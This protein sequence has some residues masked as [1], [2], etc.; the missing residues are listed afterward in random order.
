[1]FHIKSKNLKK[2]RRNLLALCISA[3]VFFSTPAIADLNF[4]AAAY[5]DIPEWTASN[6]FSLSLNFTTDVD[7]SS[8][9]SSVILWDHNG[10][11]Q[12]RIEL[13][14]G[15]LVIVLNSVTRTIPISYMT[16]D[17]I[18]LSISSL[19]GSQTLSESEITVEINGVNISPSTT[20]THPEAQNITFNRIG[21][22][23]GSPY[24]GTV[25]GEL[26]MDALSGEHRI[27]DFT[28]DLNSD[29]VVPDISL[30]D[31]RYAAQVNFASRTADFGTTGAHVV[32]IAGEGNM[33]PTD[34]DS[35][36][37]Y[38]DY[39]HFGDVFQYGFDDQSI[40]L[41]SHS[42]DIV[43]QENSLQVSPWQEFIRKGR[44]HGFITK[45]VLLVPIVKNQSAFPE[46]TKGDPSGLY[47]DALARIQA[48]LASNPNNE[49]T[50]FLW[51]QGE[52]SA[53]N[54]VSTETHQADLMN[55]YTS[56]KNDI[57]KMTDSTPFIPFL[58]Q[59]D[60]T[61]SPAGFV[62]NI[63]SAISHVAS[64]ID[65][66]QAVDT[67][68]L[69]LQSNNSSSFE[70]R[71]MIA[72]GSGFADA[73]MMV[74]NPHIDI[75]PP[76]VTL[77]GPSTIKHPIN[78]PY[79]DFGIEIYDEFDGTSTFTGDGIHHTVDTNL[80]GFYATF[81]QGSDASNNSTFVSRV[82]EIVDL[83]TVADGAGNLV[84]DE[85][86][87]TFDTVGYVDIPEWRAD[88]DFIV[89]YR[90]TAGSANIEVNLSS[91]NDNKNFIALVSGK[92]RVNIDGNFVDLPLNYQTG[93][94]IDVRIT[95]KDGLVTIISNDD[96][97]TT[98]STNGTFVLNNISGYNTGR[99]FPFSGELKGELFL[100]DRN[101]QDSRYYDM[102]RINGTEL[103][104]VQ[105]GQHATL[106]GFPSDAPLVCSPA[107]AL[108]NNRYSLSFDPTSYVSFP[109]WEA[110]GDFEINYSF[111][112]EHFDPFFPL[113]YSQD[114]GLI[115]SQD[116]DEGIYRDNSDGYIGVS[117][118]NG[119]IF[120][121]TTVARGGLATV[122]IKRENG[123]A[124]LTVN[125]VTRTQAISGTFTLDGINVLGS[126]GF[127]NPFSGKI[128]GILSLEDHQGGDNRHYD[129]NQSG[130]TVLPNLSAANSGTDGTLHNFVNGGFVV[131]ATNQGLDFDG[132]NQVTMNTWEAGGDFSI[133]YS[134]IA[135][136]NPVE[137]NASSINGT[138]HFIGLVNGVVRASVNGSSLDV[139][140]PYQEGDTINVTLNRTG[141][142]VTLTANDEHACTTATGAFVINNISGFNQ[143]SSNNAAYPYTGKLLGAMSFI[144]EGGDNRVYDFTQHDN[145]TLQDVADG[146]QDATLIG[147]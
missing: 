96:A 38:N 83:G 58:L 13:N 1:M 64:N 70:G 54:E 97:Q 33:A 105:S 124:S 145:T 20:L 115:N 57:D 82:V 131:G 132:S 17:L 80:E 117:F 12:N 116:I 65:A 98:M 91:V 106:L 39:R 85:A 8:N 111:E 112:V 139:T 28:Q 81:F 47:G 35:S 141:S 118:G 123:V 60:V 79:R 89:D 44:Q 108:E 92:L 3:P 34:S 75:I 7:S 40:S 134:L 59:P 93:E 49:L 73:V 29:W 84:P 72:L 62:A 55:M 128:S 69:R 61:D 50:A 143:N 147:Y 126:A 94:T 45:P 109:A 146:Q 114:I 103:T 95:R 15:N 21:G 31:M 100:Y 130:G 144:E 129:F 26:V 37:V 6:H 22:H 104:D 102:E 19:N 67:S 71:A 16:G 113:S 107:S 36:Y 110:N 41:A 42:L 11:A 25:S 119:S 77:V 87:L 88:G 27:Y 137:V 127:R 43:G 32:V 66:S 133:K 136:A 23:N 4:E 24:Q 18:A 125:G 68:S 63:N 90:F 52:T 48:A 121:P 140:L 76:V 14:N 120:V 2:Y 74:L 5:V 122:N 10:F 78:T 142:T 101:N 86:S 9:L 135:G 30:Q 138:R 56:F 51:G 46:W 99:S 53:I